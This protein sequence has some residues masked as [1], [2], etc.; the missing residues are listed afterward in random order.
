MIAK[1]CMH[2]RIAGHALIQSS[3]HQGQESTLTRSRHTS[4]LTV[5]GGVLLDIVH[6]TDTTHDHMVIVM[7][8][9]IVHMVLPV[10]LQRTIGQ[11]VVHPL[12]HRHWDAMDTNLQGYHTLR[13]R[14]YV[15]AIGSH[16]CTRHTQQGRIFT[17][18]HGHA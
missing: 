5:P 1:R 11:V 2:R 7:L 13:G 16:A 18:A 4:L 3:T 15:A 9:A 12:L 10:A 6:R 17:L 14:I 8:V